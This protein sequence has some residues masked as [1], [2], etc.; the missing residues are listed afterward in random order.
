MFAAFDNFPALLIWLPLA[1]GLLSFFIK[2]EKAARAT[3]IVFSLLTM[4][5]MMTSLFYTAM[6][7][8][9]LS[10]VSYVWLP[11]IGSSFGL[12]LDGLTRVLCLLTALVF[13][14]VF[15]LV[16]GNRYPNANRF[17]GLM[18]LTQ[19]GL[20][21]VFMA[22]DAL[23]FY[24]FWELALIPVYFLASIWGGGKR[25]K[26]TFKFFIY[27]FV[28]SLFLLIGI[29]YMYLKTSNGSF[30]LMAFYNV[31]LSAVEQYWMFLLFFI[32]FAIK[33]PLFPLHT[34]Q[35]EAYEQAPTPVTMV[36]SA[37]MVKM[38]LFGL[39]RWLLP[40]FPVAVKHFN[41]AIIIVIVAGMVYASLVAIYQ[42]NIKKLI[43]YSSIAHIGLMAAG[44]FTLKH[45]A[46]NG[47]VLQMFSHGINILALWIVADLVEKQ[48]GITSISKLGG[49]AKKAPVLTI[50]LVIAA[51]ANIALP[52]TNAFV[53][54]FMI[55]NGL[56]Q[57]KPWIAA[58]AGLSIILSA[59]Y[60]LNMI[61]HV[62]YGEVATAVTGFADINKMQAMVLT[63][64][65]GLIL[66]VGVYP[67]P[68]FKMMYETVGLI[69][70]RYV[71]I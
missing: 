69:V 1:G 64:I 16:P 58:F 2:S 20:M 36:L 66:F 52:L 63:V 27:T 70:N 10:Q 49:I 67:D 30:S 45:V 60:T 15:L 53:G 25:I 11:N 4:G 22:T 8:T 46:L 71:T 48:T 14:M 38:G 29:L 18:L 43:A 40:L 59:A 39:L 28:G 23:V 3:A 61:K 13:P 6:E 35:P 51:F 47:A 5:V 7:Y 68:F 34:W 41:T 21:G 31:Q 62:F 57:F 42:D 9:A 44:A 26:A 17:Y 19:C 65:T 37:V 24:L 32:A 50:F 56:Y 12:I 54:E 55:F 33:M